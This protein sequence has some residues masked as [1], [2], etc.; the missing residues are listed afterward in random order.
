MLGVGARGEGADGDFESG[1]M[2]DVGEGAAMAGGV[3]A[4]SKVE[5]GDG[6][7]PVDVAGVGIEG[8]VLTIGL[9]FGCDGDGD[10]N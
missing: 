3:A 8:G 7:T 1:A 6:G 5:V 10:A 4:G 9:G 2:D